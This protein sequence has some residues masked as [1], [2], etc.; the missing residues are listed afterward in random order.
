[1]PFFHSKKQNIYH[2]KKRG[3]AK[4]IAIEK[5]FLIFRFVRNFA[6]K[7]YFFKKSKKENP[8]DFEY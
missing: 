4:V 7:K 5:V 3:Q 6:F 2:I 8:Y 1:L